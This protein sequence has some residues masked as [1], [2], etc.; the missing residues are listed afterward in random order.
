MSANDTT[1]LHEAHKPRLGGMM[2]LLDIMG[3]EIVCDGC[4]RWQRLGTLIEADARKAATERGW[5][6]V[7]GRDICR[8]CQAEPA[9]IKDL[10][11]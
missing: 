9:K 2:S 7:D 6:F 1:T 4:G 10:G 5:A 11:I 3:G 8:V